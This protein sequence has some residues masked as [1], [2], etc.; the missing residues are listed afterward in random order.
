MGK[1]YFGRR[2]SGRRRA[3]HRPSRLLKR[4]VYQVLKVPSVDSRPRSCHTVALVTARSLGRATD[5]PVSRSGFDSAL[6]AAHVEVEGL[7]SRAGQERCRLLA[8]LGLDH[9]SV[10]TM[11]TT[12]AP[13]PSASLPEDLGNLMGKA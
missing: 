8:E 4:C 6:Q 11:A 9:P 12:P 1:P 5:R 2:E 7:L 3:R 10:G 13:P